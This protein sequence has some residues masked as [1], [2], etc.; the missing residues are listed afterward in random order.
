MWVAAGSQA[1][2]VA[3]SRVLPRRA[4]EPILCQITS[5]IDFIDSE[6]VSLEGFYGYGESIVMRGKDNSRESSLSARFLSRLS[7][8]A[9][10][11]RL[12]VT[13]KNNISILQ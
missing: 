3:L 9:T 12:P 4:L 6:T 5:T 1:A 2:I 7:I 11:K 10:G 8:S 13:C